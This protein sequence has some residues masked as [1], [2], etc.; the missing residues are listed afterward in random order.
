VAPEYAE[1]SEWDPGYRDDANWGG[2]LIRVP[3]DLYRTYG[4]LQTLRT[5]YPNMQRYMAYLATKATGGLLPT[6]LGDWEALDTSTPREYVGSIAYAQLAQNMSQIARTLG[7]RTGAHH[8]AELAQTIASAINGKYLDTTSH[9]YATGSQAADALALQIGIVPPQERIPVL[10][11]LITSIRSSGYHLAVGEVALP[12]VFDVLS[13]SGHD[14]VTYDIATQTTAPSYGAMVL[15]GTTSLPECWAGM[16]GNCSQNHVILG[17]ID[18]WFTRNLTGIAQAPSSIG[19]R[20]LIISPV[21]VGDLT[22]VAGGYETPYGRVATNW[23]RQGDGVTLTVTVP[24][25]TSAEVHVPLSGAVHTV[26][27]GTW[28]FRSSKS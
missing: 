5:Y 4:D 15:T 1:Y 19:F 2:T 10:D 20:K 7:D 22:H 23:T 12:A 17:A 9:T 21:V 6:G 3:W 26:G 14:D 28:T 11:H 27:S 24:P 13:A 16:N 25:G 18:A 8:Y